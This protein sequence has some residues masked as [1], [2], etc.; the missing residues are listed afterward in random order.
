[1]LK[2]DDKNKP[3]VCCH[4]LTEYAWRLTMF[5]QYTIDGRAICKKKIKEKKVKMYSQHPGENKHLTNV[6]KS[7][8]LLT[9]YTHTHTHKSL[10]YESF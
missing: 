4:G 7:H 10:M 8:S 2:N 6:I 5:Q 9:T 1:M 3:V